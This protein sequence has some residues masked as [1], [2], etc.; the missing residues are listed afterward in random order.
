MSSLRGKLVAVTGAAS[1]IGRATTDLIAKQGAILSLAD[2]DTKPLEQ[3]AKELTDTGVAVFWKQVDVRNQEEA[4][5]WV[6]DTVT[7]FG[8]PLDG[9]E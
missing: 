4:E 8:R 3:F 7:H 6:S 2:V 1:G 9:E 5:A